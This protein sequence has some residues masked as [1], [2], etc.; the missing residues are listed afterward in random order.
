MGTQ[1]PKKKRALSSP[2]SLSLSSKFWANSVFS[3]YRRSGSAIAKKLILPDWAT[4]SNHHKGASIHRFLCHSL[5]L[6]NIYI[7]LTCVPH[8]F[9]FNFP[10]NLTCRNSC[11]GHINGVDFGYKWINWVFI[12]YNWRSCWNSRTPKQRYCLIIIPY[13]ACTLLICPQSDFI[14][15]INVRE[16]WNWMKIKPF[17][18]DYTILSVLMG[19]LDP[20]Q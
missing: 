5:I 20:A 3:L 12:W 6:T 19:A 17:L 1:P 14:N 16:T 2:L 11:Y 9:S 10:F 13:N 15:E 8:I 7:F 4:Q 18:R